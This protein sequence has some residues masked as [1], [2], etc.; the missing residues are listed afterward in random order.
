[1]IPSQVSAHFS[2]VYEILNNSISSS[3]FLSKHVNRRN[4][5][6]V[7][8]GGTCISIF[9]HERLQR[10][11]HEANK[12]KPQNALKS[13]ISTAIIED[14]QP[15]K[16]DKKIGKVTVDSKFFDQIKFILK[17]CI[18]NYTSPT[19]GILLAHSMFLV[20][21]TYLS[22]AVAWLDGKLV[23]DMV[24]R[25]T[26]EFLKGL[27]YWFAI[28]VPATL[29]NSMIRYCQSRL[30]IELRKSLTS[31]VH[32]LYLEKNVYY[33]A[34]NLD[35]RIEGLDQLITT[36]IEKF[37]NAL[38]SMYSNLGKPLLDMV[39][40]NYQI[41]RT[42]GI[43]GMTGLMLNWIVTAR[44]MRMLSP[45]FGKLAAEEAHL[46][47][48]FRIAHSRL[49][50]NAE[51][52]AFYNGSNLE[53]SIL[54]KT[55]TALVK[56]INRTYNV[57]I[58][59]NMME[60]FVIKYAWS[61]VGLLIA[62]IP[63][64]FPQFA[65]ARTKRQQRLLKAD[66][67]ENGLPIGGL[68][69]SLADAGSR[70]MYSYKD[71]SQLAG[72]TYR[73][74]NMIRVL[75]DLRE[76]RYINAVSSQEI[77]SQSENNFSLE[78]IRGKVVY[79]L[80]GIKLSSVPI[81][82]PSGDAT[83][84]KKLSFFVKPGDHL[85]ITGPNGAGKTSILRAIS[86]IWPVFEGIIERP[87]PILS[88][89]FYVPQRPYLVLGTLRD[90]VI[91]PHSIEEMKENGK[92]D[93]DLMRVLDLVYLKYI[94][95]REG[96]WDSVKEWKDVFSG[97]EKQRMQIARVF[98]HN[99]RFLIL[100]EATSAVSN[101]VESLIYNQAKESGITI[102]TISH[103]PTLFKYHEF[104]LRIGEGPK[105]DEW[106]LEQLGSLNLQG[107]S[108]VETEIKKIEKILKEG[109]GDRMR[110]AENS[111]ILVEIHLLM[112][113]KTL[114]QL[115]HED[116]IP[117]S[118][119]VSPNY[120]DSEATLESSVPNFSVSLLPNETVNILFTTGNLT[121]NPAR[122]IAAM[123]SPRLELLQSIEEILWLQ[124]NG[125]N[126]YVDNLKN[127]S[128]SHVVELS[129]LEIMPKSKWNVNEER[130]DINITA[131]TL[132]K[133]TLQIPKLTSS[134][135]YISEVSNYL[136]SRVGINWIDT[137]IIRCQEYT[138]NSGSEFSEDMILSIYEQLE[139]HV[140]TGNISRLGVSGLS[141]Q[142][143]Q[144]LLPKLKISPKI[145]EIYLSTCRIPDD[146]RELQSKWD[147]EIHVIT[148]L[149]EILPIQ[150]L[151]SL[152]ETYQVFPDE[153][154]KITKSLWT[155]QYTVLAKKRGVLL[156]KGY[157]AIKLSMK[158]KTYGKRGYRTV[159]ETAWDREFGKSNITTQNTKDLSFQNSN[160]SNSSPT[161]STCSSPTIPS[162]QL[163]ETRPKSRIHSLSKVE[164]ENDPNEFEKKSLKNT[165][166]SE[167]SNFEPTVEKNSK[168]S[169]L[170]K[171]VKSGRR[172][173]KAFINGLIVQSTKNG[174]MNVIDG[175]SDSDSK[176]NIPLAITPMNK[177]R[178][179][180]AF[181][182]DPNQ[183][184]KIVNRNQKKR[185]N[186][187]KIQE[188]NNYLSD[189][190]L[191]SEIAEIS[192]VITDQ[193]EILPAS[194]ETLKGPLFIPSPEG[195]PN[196]ETSNSIFTPQNISSTRKLKKV[197]KSPKRKKSWVLIKNEHLIDEAQVKSPLI[198]RKSS[199]QRVVIDL[200]SEF[201]DKKD[202]F[203]NE[204]PLSSPSPSPLIKLETIKEDL[205][206]NL[207]TI[208]LD[209]T[210]INDRLKGLKLN[211][212][213]ESGST[214]FEKVYNVKSRSKKKKSKE[215]GL[216]D[217]LK[218]CD[219]K[220][221]KTFEQLIGNKSL[222]TA[223]KIG[224]ASFS[225]VFEIESNPDVDSEL[226]KQFDD[227]ISAGSSVLKIMPFDVNT[228]SNLDE[229]YGV[230]SL[231]NIFQELKI[232][233]ALSE[234]SINQR[235]ANFVE[236]FG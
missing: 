5:A 215:I 109:K 45:S 142:Q 116:F 164:K 57:K 13:P 18:P 91:Y 115:H 83:L 53:K 161:S 211:A 87:V 180:E 71:L 66:D 25:D 85:M 214:K 177:I 32:T 122:I 42:I 173:P 123:A 64:F 197:L 49:I 80:D 23:K 93:E 3:P 107:K 205:K 31:Y 189:T 86:G 47:G 21:R 104:L 184:P 90:Q 68:M 40:F 170:K 155:V 56:H 73:V 204:S 59:Y 81:T 51:E 79:G 202:V 6:L 230:Q 133:V 209:I 29:T 178:L 11:I 136:C 37:C 41:F 48:D 108:S 150:E 232:T 95:E 144:S 221:M 46:E 22:I 217:L 172:K 186:N 190:I 140:H 163:S 10:Q 15:Y 2:T 167:G 216:P 131:L 77:A 151:Q 72:Y 102:I 171:G 89:I 27:M 67:Q 120:S 26:K 220:N 231:R 228:A 219:Q 218:L 35:N 195:V 8:V 127:L 175:E 185:E 52:I 174:K 19:L 182:N 138:Q 17:I 224:E 118:G 99:P 7:G 121:T 132:R 162:P 193:Q 39:I 222:K 97:G 191:N 157:L 110:L 105:N 158:I 12:N 54:N 112:T 208:E 63:V 187:F 96:G 106:F 147:F 33:K 135:F 50:T 225:E 223:K 101:D 84:V 188:K 212:K 203:S 198:R 129:L 130:S 9:L 143:L 213:V 30:G 179:N 141:T 1:M 169:N 233:K 98:Y 166:D 24:S 44:I 58:A 200:D 154:L 148:D 28:A 75:Q 207:E 128:D 94:P 153:K 78:D 4:L 199:Y 194:P 62:S 61:A 149:S 139:Q 113:V 181:S 206:N 210:E 36:D 114:S 34:I 229:E 145:V 76:N 111:H 176:V 82:T 201:D 20:L 160:N 60:D 92:T 236:L 88:E 119:N 234:L 16:V 226:Y 159:I 156:D 137:L 65:G 124:K 74:Y 196:Q 103:R 146:L 192:P 235:G 69:L 183:I 43:A 70:F 152:V 168:N 38:A 134:I 14:Q 126:T 125:T 55:Y 165:K 100:D 227:W 117:E